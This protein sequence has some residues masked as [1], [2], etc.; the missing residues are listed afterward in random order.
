M[1]IYNDIEQGSDE[2]RGLR[3]G[4][5]TSS[6]MK[7]ILTPKLKLAD[8]DKKRTHLYELTAQRITNYVEP[9][10][11][12]DDML[13]G[14]EDEFTARD[15]YS[16]NYA[17][18]EEV[19]FI[20]EDKWGYTIGYSP[21]GLVGKD[22]LI[23]IKS[24]RQKYQI[25]TIIKDEVPEEYILQLQTGLLV[26]NRK[27]IDFVSFSAGLPMFVKRVYPDIEV[28]TKILEACSL[29]YTDLE[30]NIINYSINSC[31]LIKTE[32][33]VEGDII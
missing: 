10:Y 33:R 25:E 15:L 8:N 6:E 13:R 1:K 12:T 21:D 3:C 31:N 30:N 20:T 27:W 32:R 4:I 19:G 7:L 9:Q 29:F 23:E 26:T 18:V 2:W 22:G 16:K 28:Q 11:I 17:Q 24:R 14:F 5:L